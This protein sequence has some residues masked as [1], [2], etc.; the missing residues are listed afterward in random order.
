MTQTTNVLGGRTGGLTR[1]E[2][3]SELKDARRAV[4]HTLAAKRRDW[5]DDEVIDEAGAEEVE[6][7]AS[8]LAGAR[9]GWGDAF[10]EDDCTP[11]IEWQSRQCRP[12]RGMRLLLAMGLVSRCDHDEYGNELY[13]L[14]DG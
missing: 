9:C 12:S 5:V 14:C 2:R 7:A 11:S 10:T 1:K 6:A 8:L 3:D 4:L 13:T